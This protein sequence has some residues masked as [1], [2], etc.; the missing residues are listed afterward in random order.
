M[1]AG[2]YSFS[3][4]PHSVHD[5]LYKADPYTTYE[6]KFLTRQAVTTDVTVEMTVMGAGDA[7]SV[8]ALVCIEPGGA[9]KTMKIWMARVLDHYGP[10]NFERNMVRDGSD[11]TEIA[12]APAECATV[13]KSFVILDVPSQSSPENVKFIAWAQDPTYVWD[14]NS[15]PVGAAFAEI[16]Q[17]SKALAPFAGVFID[18]F[19]AGDTMRWSS[20]TP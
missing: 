5:G 9:G 6:S 2:L 8:S 3:Y 13:T 17:A 7:W 1:R 12:L 10:A 20:A 18:G 15:P 16:Y 4:I 19:E 14:P 11:A